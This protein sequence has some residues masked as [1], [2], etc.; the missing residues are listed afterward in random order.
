MHYL[1]PVLG[2]SGNEV[3][4]LRRPFS[5]TVI[6]RVVECQS[7]TCEARRGT[8]DAGVNSIEAP[9]MCD[10][11]FFSSPPAEGRAEMGES[12]DKLWK[13]KV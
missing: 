5:I 13:N 2:E 7:E 11:A 9:A 6:Y 10:G 3:K 12:K 8:K 4:N 1:T